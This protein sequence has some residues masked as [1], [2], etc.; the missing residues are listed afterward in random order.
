[1]GVENNISQ[2]WVET[3][4]GEVCEIKYGKDHKK[5]NLTKNENLSKVFGK[6]SIFHASYIK[7]ETNIIM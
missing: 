5:L 4:L 6:D 2:D 3:T 7:L 1:M